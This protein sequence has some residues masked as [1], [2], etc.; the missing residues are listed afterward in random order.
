MEPLAKSNGQP[1]SQ[2]VEECLN[3]ARILIDQLPLLDAEKRRLGNDV[4][5]GLAFHDT[6]KAATGFQKVMLGEAENWGGKRHEI[7]SASFASSIPTLNEA[8]IFA[9]LTHHK[10]IPNSELR[11][12]KRALDF[13]S[14]PLDG[15]T[16]QYLSW[17]RMKSEWLD[18]YTSFRESWEKICKKIKR[19]DLI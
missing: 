9:I 15:K 19:E 10:S 3:V 4:A 1:L 16:E 8:V 5:L 2:H 18:N 13:D 6:G 11:E 12:E 14:L 17:K 7:L